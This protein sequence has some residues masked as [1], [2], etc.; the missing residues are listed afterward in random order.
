MLQK[1]GGTQ[2]QPGILAG[3]SLEPTSSMIRFT[4]EINCAGLN[5]FVKKPAAPEFSHSFLVA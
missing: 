2:L 4:S 3:P 5:G 1:S